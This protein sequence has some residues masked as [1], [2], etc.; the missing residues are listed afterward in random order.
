VAL[1]GSAVPISA[2]AQ[3]SSVPIGPSAECENEFRLCRCF[4]AGIA[5]FRRLF[6]EMW[7]Q[8]FQDSPWTAN[9]EQISMLYNL[10]KTRIKLSLV[11]KSMRKEP[12]E[13]WD[14]PVWTNLLE[15][16]HD[17]SPDLHSTIIQS[18][19]LK[20]VSNKLKT[21][22]NEFYHV[23]SNSETRYAELLEKVTLSLV[24]FGLDISLLQ[25]NSP[26][27]KLAPGGNDAEIER[28]KKLGN[29]EYAKNNYSRAVDYYTSAL[30]LNGLSDHS[31]AILYSN[32]SA[33][34]YGMG[35]YRQA[36]TDAQNS[37]DLSPGW[38]KPLFWLGASYNARGRYRKA[39]R[40]LYESESKTPI[41]VGLDW[42]QKLNH[43]IWI[44]RLECSRIERGE[45]SIEEMVQ[46][47]PD[48]VL[49]RIELSRNRRSGKT[50]AQIRNSNR[51][52]AP[53]LA[54]CGDAHQRMSEM[55]FEEAFQL[56][57][58]AAKGGSSEGMFNVGLMFSY[59][60]GVKRDF[61]K[62][63]EWLKKA[64][65]APNPKNSPFTALMTAAGGAKYLRLGVGEAFHQLAL[66]AESG[67]GG[68]IDHPSAANYYQQA[69]D[70]NGNPS[71]MHNL[72]QKYMYGIGVP[73]D[74]KMATEL[75]LRAASHHDNHTPPMLTLGELFLSQGDKENAAF[76]L[77]K[78]SDYGNHHAT[79]LLPLLDSLPTRLLPTK[80][81]PSPNITF[82]FKNAKVLHSDQKIARNMKNRKEGFGRS[83]D[84]SRSKPT[85]FSEATVSQI[86]EHLG[87]TGS[88][89]CRRIK[90]TLYEIPSIH[91][92]QLLPLDRIPK[93]ICETSV[94]LWASTLRVN[95]EPI[96]TPPLLHSL[97]QRIL[98]GNPMHRDALLVMAY[99]NETSE[100]PSKIS[101][102]DKCLRYYPKD[103]AFW[104]LRA[105]L[106][107]HE[108][109][110]NKCLADVTQALSIT[111]HAPRSLYRQWIALYRLYSES[112]KSKKSGKSQKSQK[113]KSRDTPK[114]VLQQV[115]DAANC[116][117]TYSEPDNRD[118]HQVMFLMAFTLEM[119]N[120]SRG[121]Q[122]YLLGK[123][124]AE[125]G[126][127]Y[128]TNTPSQVR[129]IL[130]S[131][132]MESAG[133]VLQGVLPFPLPR[134]PRISWH[135]QPLIMESDQVHGLDIEGMCRNLSS[136]NRDHI[137][138]LEDFNAILQ[139]A[140]YSPFARLILACCNMM[141]VAIQESQTQD[142]VQ[143]P[144]IMLLADSFAVSSELFS[145]LSPCIRHL[146]Y[147]FEAE[148]PQ[149]L[150]LMV[151]RAHCVSPGDDGETEEDMGS[152]SDSED[153]EDSEGDEENLLYNYEA[154]SLHPLTPP[155]LCL[156]AS[157]LLQRQVDPIS[158]QYDINRALLTDP[159]NPRA[160]Y[161]RVTSFFCM[162]H[163]LAD[164]SL[165]ESLNI[166][167]DDA[168]RIIPLDDH[169]HYFH[170]MAI[171]MTL[172]L[173]GDFSQTGTVPPPS[174]KLLEFFRA[175]RS[176]RNM[177]AQLPGW[178][179]DAF[180]PLGHNSSAINF[181][182]DMIDLHQE[183]NPKE[184]SNNKPEEQAP[185]A[186]E[187]PG[188]WRALGNLIPGWGH[189]SG[190]I[191]R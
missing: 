154:L 96:P 57:L 173:L 31:R 88:L 85:I 169:P 40:R 71:S 25:S 164:D 60:K 99:P 185:P 12:Y 135:A 63:M 76:W 75:L 150:E 182:D 141:H 4:R 191:W 3:P 103:A 55:R 178:V 162:W 17:L 107:A 101:L 27:T 45:E 156:S 15:A 30:A 67:I 22:R 155:L 79:S 126:I 51:S 72:A 7:F 130:D 100:I 177:F 152:D 104:T 122:Y 183:E 153:E 65:S 5:E 111:P 13:A 87:K 146:L 161:L 80:A 74:L 184:P 46:L 82:D 69:I 73:S 171:S 70:I 34:Y 42:R 86:N 41:D 168:L 49:K 189:I 139:L 97:A 190:M 29:E 81:P 59:G 58:N 186:E 120:D 21:L 43:E 160:L 2:L 143:E 159:A 37:L 138:N 1:P 131:T 157:T 129:Q 125:E 109:N 91:P 148:E 8:R 105:E 127:P 93:T 98:Q 18:S 35:E 132:V 166:A 92:L 106:H 136:E 124:L 142:K 26:H 116:L 23:R 115:V 134:P 9:P 11:L 174:E 114:I 90:E 6:L 20:S 54:N 19:K 38:F 140:T 113:S 10:V 24:E 39:L 14:I 102:L 108:G 181:I 117:L 47:S 175:H 179:N 64:S 83:S 66:F 180:P 188:F 163:P 94:S 147:A 167:I 53:H 16:F 77:R 145:Y 165:K 112:K 33:A 119:E 44:S 144:T 56:F 176:I 32:R 187:K 78:A 158:P 121:W 137:D 52:V 110:W 50:A 172:Q 170:I 61:T 68:P 133:M 28:L 36:Q 48:E 89:T 128:F 123:Q 84:T 118:L 151:L 149:S 62:A 95:E